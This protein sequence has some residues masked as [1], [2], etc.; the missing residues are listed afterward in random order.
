MPE[1]PA[2]LM[3][4]PLPGPPPKQHRSSQPRQHAASAA[5]STPRGPLQ[6]ITNSSKL[7]TPA[8]SSVR[9][10]KASSYH[11]KARR[12]QD[13]ENLHAK[14]EPDHRTSG[15]SDATDKSLISSTSG[16]DTIINMSRAHS[17][18]RAVGSGG[19]SGRSSVPVPVA[20]T[21]G[22]RSGSGSHDSTSTSN[23]NNRNSA[24]DKES[25]Q[26][27]RRSIRNSTASTL[28]PIYQAKLEVMRAHTQQLIQHGYPSPA[29]S[30]SSKHGSFDSQPASPALLGQFQE[31]QRQ[32][33]SLKARNTSLTAENGKLLAA[34]GAAEAAAE[35]L[36][37]QLRAREAEHARLVE[38]FC[39][40]TSQRDAE[41]R[42]V[43]ESMAVLKEE[44]RRLVG[45]ITKLEQQH[46]EQQ[47]QQQ[48]GAQGG[49][50]P[51]LVDCSRSCSRSSRGSDSA[52]ESVGPG[53]ESSPL[54]RTS[55]NN[56][57]VS[58]YTPVSSRADCD[59]T[60]TRLYTGDPSPSLRV[61]WR[62][63]RQSVAESQM[64]TDSAVED[65]LAALSDQ[66][67]VHYERYSREY[68]AMT[69]QLAVLAEEKAQL[70]KDLAAAREQQV[71]IASRNR[72][73]ESKLA[74]QSSPLQASLVPPSLAP[75]PELPVLTYA[76]PAS[77][78][79]DRV[80]SSFKYWD[81]YEF[82]SQPDV[83]TSPVD[84]AR[85]ARRL[86][87]AVLLKRAIEDDILDDMIYLHTPKPNTNASTTTIAT[88]AS[89][90]PGHP[91]AT[92]VSKLESPYFLFQTIGTLKRTVPTSLMDYNWL[93]R[94]SDTDFEDIEGFASLVLCL[95]R[96][97]SKLYG[98]SVDHYDALVPKIQE[99]M[100]KRFPD[101]EKP[102][103]ELASTPKKWW[104]LSLWL[105]KIV[106]RRQ[107]RILGD[108]S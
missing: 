68:A 101:L 20:A 66:L 106:K 31:L 35:D 83:V 30:L 99:N 32:I 23:N 14:G 34:K 52:S 37:A 72:E 63:R 41:V 38:Q 43:R 48:A 97:H 59:S 8:S 77:V 98:T 105:S 26:P 22:S 74:L 15:A 55:S 92:P 13:Q 44:R 86:R 17:T 76:N 81:L 49:Q 36:R 73:L 39:V 19:T 61:Q 100:S 10:S 70:E 56:H 85:E 54:V 107:G 108:D 42:R 6:E 102:L 95:D 53:V 4:K 64:T 25:H 1:T 9:S 16:A 84:P 3:D 60:V 57:T 103:V 89:G 104:H 28:S 18:N 51:V 91:H 47:Q 11:G 96:R 79:F 82:I 29:L 21:P 12:A 75:I 90:T 65:E 33:Q 80:T 7:I 93:D 58:P 88:T 87:A 5:T 50:I 69:A 45:R 46:K 78:W 62:H 27:R 67:A 40:E 71:L 24:A 94:I 2:S